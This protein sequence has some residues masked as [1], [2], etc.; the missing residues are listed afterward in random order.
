MPPQICDMIRLWST[1]L[2]NLTVHALYHTIKACKALQGPFTTFGIA[3]LSGSMVRWLSRRSACSPRHNLWYPG[4]IILG[5]LALLIVLCVWGIHFAGESLLNEV[6]IHHL[7]YC[8]RHRCCI[9]ERVCLSPHI[10]LLFA[11]LEV[12]G[13]FSLSERGFCE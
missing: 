9:V 4:V 5:S 13:W 7:N 8:R 6:L 3:V 11:L 2:T 12:C 1:G 10:Q